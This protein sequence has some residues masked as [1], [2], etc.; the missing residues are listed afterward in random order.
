[1]SSTVYS[2]SVCTNLYSPITLSEGRKNH[3]RLKGYKCQDIAPA[4][5]VNLKSFKST[6]PMCTL[7]VHVY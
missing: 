5:C 4:P 7:Y 3:L 6:F 2:V 1:M